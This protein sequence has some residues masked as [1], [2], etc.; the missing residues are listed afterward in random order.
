M[1]DP[2]SAFAMAQA[3]IAG[4]R[5]CVDLYKEAKA[6]AADVTDIT[7]E[8]TGH[9]GTFLEAKET[10]ETATEEIKKK[11]PPK[12]A[13]INKQAFDNI[14][15]V[16]QLQE[17]EKEL[18]EFMIYHTPNWGGIW[19]EFEAERKRLQK[20]ADKAESEA[21]KLHRWQFGKEKPS[22]KNMSILQQFQLPYSFWCWNSFFLCIMSTLNIRNQNITWRANNGLA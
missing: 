13:S 21:K 6:V 12:G 15:R 20:E 11:P 19:S 1:I 4:V 5:K 2:I 16:R 9:I 18:R 14:M 17:A 22:F 7:H 8:V 3:A 10:L